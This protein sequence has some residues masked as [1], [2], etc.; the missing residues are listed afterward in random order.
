M[1]KN[2]DYRI[3]SYR[4][5]TKTLFSGK[6]NYLLNY[7]SDYVNYNSIDIIHIHSL[8]NSKIINHCFSIAPVVRTMHEPRMFC[9]GQGKFWRLS[10]RVCNKPFGI[11]CV[12]HAYKEGCCNRHPIRLIKSHANVLFETSNLY[13]A[14][15][16]HNAWSSRIN[17]LKDSGIPG[18]GI[19][20]PLTT[21][22]YTHLTLPTI[23]LV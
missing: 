20:K 10:E 2:S 9:P 23:L 11:H 13:V 5:S 7:L 4:N 3:L 8:S 16:R 6:L 14:T 22:S 15:S 17:T 1:Y 21:V 18:L 19:G 12:Y